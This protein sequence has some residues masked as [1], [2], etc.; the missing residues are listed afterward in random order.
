[1]EKTDEVY[2]NDYECNYCNYRFNARSGKLR[3]T[4]QGNKVLKN[5]IKCPNCGI[6]LK[7]KA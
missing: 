1:M 3:V 6:F 5:F 7:N 4:E 2:Y